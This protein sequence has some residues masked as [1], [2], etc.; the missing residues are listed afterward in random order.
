MSLLEKSIRQ[1]VS[2][3]QYS[4]LSAA[5]EGIFKARSVSEEERGHMSGL[6]VHFVQ[7]MQKMQILHRIDAVSL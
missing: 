3:L 6:S 1:L 4:S 2:I 7:K 5:P